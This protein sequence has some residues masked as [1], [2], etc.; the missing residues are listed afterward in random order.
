MTVRKPFSLYERVFWCTK[1]F[2]DVREEFAI[3]YKCLM[4]WRR[5]NPDLL[6][7]ILHPSRCYYRVKG[8]KTT[9]EL[10]KMEI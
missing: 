5:V 10:K 8:K 9:S 7:Y 3:V 6:I 4:S 1:G 2:Y